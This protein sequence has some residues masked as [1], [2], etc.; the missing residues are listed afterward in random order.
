V[1]WVA[2]EIVSLLF[3]EW[4][5]IRQCWREISDKRGR[6][7]LKDNELKLRRIRRNKR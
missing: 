2:E 3:L 5:N 1:D 7:V 4:H 6:R